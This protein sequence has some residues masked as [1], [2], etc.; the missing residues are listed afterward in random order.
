[1][2]LESKNDMRKRGASSPDFADALIYA[3]AN[4]TNPTFVQNIVQW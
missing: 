1:M 2:L 3:L 4:D